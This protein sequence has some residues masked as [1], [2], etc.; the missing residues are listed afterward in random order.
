MHVRSQKVANGGTN[1]ISA[2]KGVEAEPRPDWD[3]DT[4]P[5]RAKW[6]RITSMDLTGADAIRELLPYRAAFEGAR[7]LSLEDPDSNGGIRNIDARFREAQ[8]RVGVLESKLSDARLERDAACRER[9]ELAAKLESSEALHQRE[10]AEA[11]VI[12]SRADENYRASIAESASRIADLEE[13]EQTYISEITGALDQLL[14]SQRT[15]EDTERELG[16]SRTER[17]ALQT[18]ILALKEEQDKNA[19]ARLAAVK[20]ARRF[21]DDAEVLMEENENLRNELE[22]DSAHRR[23][24]SIHDEIRTRRIEHLEKVHLRLT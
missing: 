24:K 4:N 18:E 8:E 20:R 9:D 19:A 14:V 5:K 10:L 16:Q 15:L 1:G 21:Q 13:R 12:A 11:N 6:H 17:D 2:D 22:G 3:P 7:R 23:R